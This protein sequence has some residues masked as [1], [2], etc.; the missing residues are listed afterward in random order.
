MF[1]IATRICSAMF[2]AC[3]TSSLRR[4]SVSGVC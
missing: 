2:F 4:S 3:F 1:L